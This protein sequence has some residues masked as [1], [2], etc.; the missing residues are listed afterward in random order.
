MR[1]H[2]NI[3]KM[4]KIYF[5]MLTA[6]LFAFSSGVNAQNIVITE[7]MYNPP[8]AGTDSLE[9][10]E[11]YNND[12]VAVD[13][14][15]WTFTHGINHTF[16]VVSMN[17]GEYLVIAKNPS[18]ILNVYGYSGAI[19]WNSGALANGGEAIVIATAG[20]AQ[21]IDSVYYYNTAAWS[22]AQANGNGA[23][24]VLCDPNSDNTNPVNWFASTSSSSVIVNGIV[25]L[26]SPGAEDDVCPTL[27]N[28]SSTVFVTDCDSYTVPS[29]NEIYT[30]S[31]T[32]M[33]T[34]ANAAG[35][36]SVITINLTIN[37]AATGTDV[38]TACGSFTWIDG[39]A[40]TSSNNTATE[41]II[42]GAANGCD[43]IVA[44]DLTINSPNDAGTGDTIT[45]CMNQPIDFDTLS[46]LGTTGTWLDFTNTPVSGVNS[47]ALAGIY[48]YRYI[49]YTS[50]NCVP[51]TAFYTIVID[52]GCDY[53]NINQEMLTDISIYPNPA[54]SVLSIL[55]PSN[56]PFLKVEISDLNGRIVLVENDLSNNS[57][58]VRI[59]IENLQKGI[60]TLRIYNEKAQKSFKIVK[61]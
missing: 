36:D 53:L 9:F 47:I 61:Q 26:G 3:F 24:I 35:C 50:L 42:G 59:S 54:S 12:N 14:T 6:L 4:M 57:S 39:V 56:T 23:S 38:Q 13:L 44:L 40:Y 19:A 46:R 32:Y 58:N 45:V 43:S 2:N 22:G 1:E 11:L 31:G 51:D 48:E 27:C 28:S 29:G 8:E 17:P 21:T 7:I 33:D 52:G 20:G 37:N 25:V 30:V 41:I 5:F 49:V 10:I 16:G 34:I 60:Y 15:G 18:A 55:N